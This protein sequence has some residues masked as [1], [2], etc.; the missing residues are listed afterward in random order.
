MYAGAGRTVVGIWKVTEPATDGRS[1]EKLG[2]MLERL[3]MMSPVSEEVW[4]CIEGEGAGAIAGRAPSSLA[5]RLLYM[6]ATL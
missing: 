6:G 2:A 1:L 3:D 4:R 5:R